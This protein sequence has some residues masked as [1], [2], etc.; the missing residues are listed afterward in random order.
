MAP[1]CRWQPSQIS[2]WKTVCRIIREDIR[3]KLVAQRCQWHRCDMQSGVNDTA[4]TSTSVSLT[5]LCNQLCRLSSR[6][7]SHIK[8]G[9]KLCIR[10]PVKVVWWKK[11]MSKM[12]CQV[13]FKWASTSIKIF[14]AKLIT[15]LQIEI[16]K[17]TIRNRTWIFGYMDPAKNFP[18]SDQYLFRIRTNIWK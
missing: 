9:F 12:S 10:D 18:G 8:K 17:L 3:K 4:V 16:L 14:L 11:Q 1:L 7:Q 2:L 13:P 15:E 6:I 5:P